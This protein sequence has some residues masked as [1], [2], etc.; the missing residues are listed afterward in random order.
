MKSFVKNVYTTLVWKSGV[1]FLVRTIREPRVVAL[2]YHSIWDKRN[3]AALHQSRYKHISVAADM[4]QQHIAYMHDRGYT[5][6]QF[7]EANKGTNGKEVYLYFDDGFLD[8]YEN[9]Y[10]ILKNQGIRATLFVTTDYIDQ[11]G[12][13]DSY[14]SWEQVQSMQDVFEIGAHSLTHKKLSKISIEDARREM[15]D[16]KK[17]IEEKLGHGIAAFSYPHGRSNDELERVAHEVGYEI[18]TADPFFHKVRPD[19]EDSFDTFRFKVS[20]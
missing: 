12:G 20:L 9:A 16:S 13:Y 4:L 15:S 1:G 11:K 17:V 8:V 10:P 7:H 2:A 6:K 19:P 18:T 14:L 5:F 3:V